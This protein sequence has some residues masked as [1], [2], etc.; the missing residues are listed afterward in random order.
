M[1]KLAYPT[2]SYITLLPQRVLTQLSS[3]F[4]QGRMPPAKSPYRKLRFVLRRTI[5]YP[6]S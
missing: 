2:F 3:G 4:E 6:R 5:D 1:Y